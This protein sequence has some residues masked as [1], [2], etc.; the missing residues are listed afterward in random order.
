ME[1]SPTI[2]GLRARRRNGAT[3]V[4]APR[5]VPASLARARLR[6]M[7]LKLIGPPPRPD[8]VVSAPA[9]L[10]EP[11]PAAPG[12]TLMLVR[13][14]EVD[15]QFM[16]IAYGSMD[17]PLSNTGLEST[18]RVTAAFDGYP[19]DRVLSSDLERALAMGR[20]IAQSTGAELTIT[21]ALR[22]VNRGEWQGIPRDEFIANWLAD[23]A[24]YWRDPWNWKTPRGDCDADLWSRGS[25]AVAGELAQLDGGTLAVTA[26]TNLI[27]VLLGGFL[28]VPTP[29][30]YSFETGAAHL[31]VLVLEGDA[32]THAARNL[33]RPPA[34]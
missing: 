16:S 1:L 29:Q 30:N 11:P 6:V 22:E 32:W 18:R 15:E 5:G 25:A 31:H 27:R 12:T 33:D 26:H 9:T 3:G 34:G 4:V 23:A 10:P 17:V 8:G 24:H 14:A 19:V 2:F 13:H 20:G 21:R 7:A 28:G